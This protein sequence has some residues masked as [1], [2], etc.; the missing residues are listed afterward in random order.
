MK[1]SLPVQLFAA[2]A[3]TLLVG[4][5]ST[6]AFI[7]FTPNISGKVAGWKG[8]D[9]VLKI[10]NTGVPVEVGTLKADG[11]FS[12]NLF[13]PPVI[14]QVS[15]DPVGCTV[16]PPDL[17]VKVAIVQVYADS[18]S[19]EPT[20]YL[21]QTPIEELNTVVGAKTTQIYRIFANKDATVTCNTIVSIAGSWNLKNGWN[22][23]IEEE[24][25][26]EVTNNVITKKRLTYSMG[27]RA[28]PWQIT[29]LNE[30]GL[31]GSSIIRQ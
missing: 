16:T 10:S 29:A 24:E 19:N 20:N 7:G 12:L 27:N 21:T 26:L 17:K 25:V 9:K 13:S 1:N 15:Y 23:V 30:P 14:E 11:S 22:E 8:G 2:S 4:C 5:G 28:I 3:I 31:F 18:N 6:S